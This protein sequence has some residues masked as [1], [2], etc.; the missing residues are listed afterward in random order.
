[1]LDSICLRAEWW[2]VYRYFLDIRFRIR[3]RNLNKFIWW[4]LHKTRLIGKWIRILIA[5]ANQKIWRSCSFLLRILRYLWNGLQLWWELLIF[6]DQSHLWLFWL[7]WS[8]RWLNGSFHLSGL[9]R[10]YFYYQV[11]LQRLSKHL[12]ILLSNAVVELLL[13]VNRARFVSIYLPI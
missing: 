10:P 8:I 1:M 4:L 3:K 6:I 5:W 13:R 7:I 12:N 11:Y 2:L 9:S